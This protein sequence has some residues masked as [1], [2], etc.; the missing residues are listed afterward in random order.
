MLEKGKR[1]PP[2]VPPLKFEQAPE[3]KLSPRTKSG[4]QLPPSSEPLSAK[5]VPDYE[6]SNYDDDDEGDD[7][8]IPQAKSLIVKEGLAVSQDEDEDWGICQDGGD[9]LDDDDILFSKRDGFRPERNEE[10]DY[11]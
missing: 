11:I 5:M 8:G 10:V 6:L 2:P 9:G 4:P 7:S 3:A 1:I